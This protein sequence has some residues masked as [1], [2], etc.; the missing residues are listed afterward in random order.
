MREKGLKRFRIFK[1]EKESFEVNLRCAP[2]TKSQKLHF[3]VK[4]IMW[5][6][7]LQTLLRQCGWDDLNRNGLGG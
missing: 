1:T 6:L 5:L 3:F 4:G 2:T 7:A